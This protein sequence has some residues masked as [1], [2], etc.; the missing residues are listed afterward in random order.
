V[1]VCG[2]R[3]CGLCQCGSECCGL[4]VFVGVCGWRCCGVGYVSVV[5][6][7]VV[8]WCLWVEVLGC[9]S[10]NEETM[11]TGVTAD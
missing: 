7:V 6:N 4:L 11:R 1:G 9:V 10:V 8:C 5:V 3:C 2:W